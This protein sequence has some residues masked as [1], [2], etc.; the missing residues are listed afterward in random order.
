MYRKL[1][2]EPIRYN[3]LLSQTRRCLS[4]NVRRSVRSPASTLNRLDE[5]R[6]RLADDEKDDLPIFNKFVGD[7]QK[8]DASLF[9][10][11]ARSF[12]R[13][14]EIFNL[15][16]DRG[17]K[18]GEGYVGVREVL[19]ET[20]ANSPESHVDDEEY[21]TTSSKC[22]HSAPDEGEGLGRIHASRFRQLARRRCRS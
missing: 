12:L 14:A 20:K 19:E 21:R 13:A 2:N 22:R 11:K 4:A 10:E 1:I 7:D 6:A 8:Y 5:L 3:R 16:Y 15:K 17:G 18:K 9:S